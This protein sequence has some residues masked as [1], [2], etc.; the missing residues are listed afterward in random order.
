[1]LAETGWSSVFFLL[2]TRLK[3]VAAL[4]QTNAPAAAMVP[5]SCARLISMT[6]PGEDAGQSASSDSSSGASEPS[7]T[8]NEAPPI[9]QSDNIPEQPAQPEAPQPPEQTAY[10]PPPAYTPP[11]SYETPGYQQPPGY[12]NF[13][14]PD[15]AAPTEY[16]QPGGAQ[17]G[18]P[19]PPY[20][21][22]PG[23][24]AQAYPPPP[25]YGAP[26]YGAPP[27]GYAPPPPGYGPPPT[28]Y[29]APDY[30]AYG[31]PAQKTNSMAI[32]SLVSSLVGFL[33]WLGAIGG[34]V[35]GVIALNQIKQTQEEGHGLAIAGIAIGALSLVVGLLI[36]MFAITG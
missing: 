13:P 6:N 8:G 9:E 3:F 36:F 22:P 21:G 20:P 15:Y 25:P 10:I 5:C 33:C 31:Q 14:P 11:P 1:V 30:S 32:A 19:P 17:Q 18:Y 2:Y 29:P 4:I 23:Y 28:G 7:S 24:G 35:L 16:P 34:I 12:P 26:Q 27:P